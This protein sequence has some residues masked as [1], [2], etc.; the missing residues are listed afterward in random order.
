MNV[1]NVG[2]KK[3]TEEITPMSEY[4]FGRASHKWDNYVLSAGFHGRNEE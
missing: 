1:P 3:E 2:R 4:F